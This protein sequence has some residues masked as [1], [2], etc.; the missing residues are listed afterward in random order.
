MS[1]N[2]QVRRYCFTWNNYPDE[3]ITKMNAMG[4]LTP[5]PGYKEILKKL[6]YSYIICGK[7]IAPTTGTPH[8][9][10]YV[11]F[12]S[13]KRITTMVKACPG[14]KFIPCK[15]DADSNQNY[16]SKDAT[17]I[18]EEGDVKAQG[19]RTD[20]TEAM[21]SI[22]EGMDEM[23]FFEQHT[24]TAV[25]YPKAMEKYRLLCDKKR[26]Q[27][28]HKKTVLVYWGQ[29]GTGKTRS[30]IEEYPDAFIVSE[31]VSGLWWDGYDGEKTVVMDE[32]RG[33]V[34]ISQLLRILDGYA[35]QVSIK[36]GSRQLFADT[37]IITSNTDP[38]EW[39]KGCDARS[40]EALIRRFDDIKYF[41]RSQ[42]SSELDFATEVRVGNSEL[43][44]S[45]KRIRDYS[46]LAEIQKFDP[47]G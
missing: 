30:A 12:N 3:G 42:K 38:L 43:P 20:I 16:C 6:K 46:R 35:C 41:E 15:G 4:G 26:N 17:D 22:R 14:I 10:G 45:G 40:R 32:F 19:A 7:E 1:D 5:V 47:M 44:V 39:Y 25:R 9:Q 24:M 18:W 11:E 27:G 33:N 13:G 21:S 31:G 28:F 29:T 37:I 8:L 34:P 36:G 2:K 23:T